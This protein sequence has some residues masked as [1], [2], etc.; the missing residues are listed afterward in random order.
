MQLHPRLGGK[1]AQAG[2]EAFVRRGGAVEQIDRLVAVL[3]RQRLQAGDEGGDADA[4]ADF[5]S[6]LQR[7]GRYARDVY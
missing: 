3:L 4:A 1:L 2:D 5:L 7:D 6:Q